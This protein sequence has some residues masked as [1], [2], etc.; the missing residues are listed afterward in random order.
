MFDGVALA[1]AVAF[2]MGKAAI[3]KHGGRQ[4]VRLDDLVTAAQLYVAV[5]SIRKNAVMPTVP[6]VGKE[7]A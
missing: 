6:V 7:Q 2:L 5:M 3:R 4:P 1:A